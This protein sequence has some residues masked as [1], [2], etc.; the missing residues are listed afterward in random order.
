MN[1]RFPSCDIAALPTRWA[2][3][4]LGADTE[5]RSAPAA[6][7]SRVPALELQPSWE[8]LLGRR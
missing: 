6:H 4:P 2:T 7:G 8:D 1:R 5:R 3:V